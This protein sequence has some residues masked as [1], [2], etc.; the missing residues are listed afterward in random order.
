MYSMKPYCSNW[1]YFGAWVEVTTGIQ[2]LETRDATKRATMHR[3]ALQR[4]FSPQIP[5]VPRLRNLV[6]DE[7]M[8]NSFNSE[9]LQELNY[10]VEELYPF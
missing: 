7:Y 5:I 9:Y 6:L 2:W 8:P 4:I 3:V 10:Y 1:I